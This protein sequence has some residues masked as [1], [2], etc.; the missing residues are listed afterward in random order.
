MN[1]TPLTRR[2]ILGTTAALLA[3][4][5]GFTALPAAAQTAVERGLEIAVEAETSALATPKPI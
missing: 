5:A 1:T 2:S 3:L 4:S